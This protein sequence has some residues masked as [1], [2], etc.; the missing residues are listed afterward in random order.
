[1]VTALAL[2]SITLAV[3]LATFLAWRVNQPAVR[4]TVSFVDR[5]RYVVGFLFLA[6]AAY[7]LIQSGDPLSIAAAML[8]MAFLTGYALV[9]RPWQGTI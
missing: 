9:E 6:L 5:I 2:V 4:A 8:G 1:M 3:V 7:H